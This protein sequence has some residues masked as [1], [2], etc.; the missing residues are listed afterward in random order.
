[1]SQ[2]PQQPEVSVD[3]ILASTSNLAVPPEAGHPTPTTPAP[4]EASASSAQQSH[5][6]GATGPSALSVSPSKAS[7]QVGLI[8][9]TACALVY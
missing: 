4:T 8:P 2:T 5:A 3:S 9:Y 1:M 6:Q 7:Y